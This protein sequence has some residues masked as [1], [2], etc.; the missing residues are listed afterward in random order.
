MH[1]WLLLFVGLLSCAALPAAGGPRVTRRGLAAAARYS[2]ARG[3]LSLIVWRRGRTVLERYDNGGSAKEP[4]RLASCVKSLWG[5][6]AVAAAQDGLL[7]LDEPVAAT[8]GDWA[9]DEEKK[10]ATVRELL[11][12][13]AGVVPGGDV[14]YDDATADVRAA[15]LRLPFDAAPG[16]SFQYG[17]AGME[18]FGE[19]LARKLGPRGE[20]PRAYLERRLLRPLGVAPAEWRE[21]A[22]G[23]PWMSSGAK[24]TARGLLRIGRLV[25]GQGRARG[26]RILD[27]KALAQLF[28]GSAANPMYG[29]TFWLNAGA[30]R[31]DAVEVDV[32]NALAE[33]RA[34]DW[35]RACL[36]R[37][38]PPDLVAMVGSWNQRLYVVPSLGLV[39][40]RQGAGGDFRDAE[41]LRLLLQ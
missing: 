7:D 41:F 23:H 25:L 30:T 36:S 2:A 17:P 32:E 39:V 22:A 38:A 29:L 15:A 33:G 16:A 4:V 10:A 5:L 27:R 31:K 37:A 3:G 24:L 19:I 11:S 12:M 40:V 8:L 20:T 34:V 21:D 13:T 35:G 26:A 14:I 28:K 6:A 18:L 1:R 9:D